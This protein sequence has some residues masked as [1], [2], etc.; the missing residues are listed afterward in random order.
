MIAWVYAARLIHPA[1]PFPSRCV[2]F[3]S[4]V[5]AIL[6][7]RQL[8]V[9]RP[10]SADYTNTGYTCYRGP[11]FYGKSCCTIWGGCGCPSGYTDT[12][13]TCDRI[14]SSLGPSSM[15][16]HTAPA[17][18]FAFIHTRLR[19]RLNEQAGVGHSRSACMPVQLAELRSIWCRLLP[20]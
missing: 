12:G 16:R 9:K 6:C 4:A 11:Y 10:C 13:C 17:R 14:A 1:S 3:I 8:V 2:D 18:S 5:Y 7:I 15:V 20:E 19:S